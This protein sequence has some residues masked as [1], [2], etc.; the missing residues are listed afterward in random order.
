MGFA[1]ATSVPL[2]NDELVGSVKQKDWW[3]FQIVTAVGV[4]YIFGINDSIASRA[5]AGEVL[6]TTC[7]SITMGCASMRAHGCLRLT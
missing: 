4:T 7:I 5:L 3:V 2:I 6:K 1:L